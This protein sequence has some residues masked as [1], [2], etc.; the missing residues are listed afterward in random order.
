[1]I[2]FVPIIYGPIRIFTDELWCFRPI[3][4]LR[5][6]GSEFVF[7]FSRFRSRRFLIFDLIVQILIVKTQLAFGSPYVFFNGSLLI[8]P[9]TIIFKSSFQYVSRSRLTI[10][11][12]R[13]FGFAT[14]WFSANNLNVRPIVIPSRD[15]FFFFLVLIIIFIFKRA[16]NGERSE[17]V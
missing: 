11:C 12:R 5:M 3:A 10:V 13:L 15:G 17:Y 7:R 2:R 8:T 14:K 1:M 4:E 9:L 16:Q 6:D